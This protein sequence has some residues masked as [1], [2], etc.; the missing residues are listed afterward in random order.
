MVST[1]ASFLVLQMAVPSL[2]P[3]MIF[4]LCVS[5]SLFFF[6]RTPVI[7]DYGF[8]GGCSPK[9]G[10][11]GQVESWVAAQPSSVP[12]AAVLGSRSWKGPGGCCSPNPPTHTEG[13]PRAGEGKAAIRGPAGCVTDSLRPGPLLWLAQP[14]HLEQRD[15][16]LIQVWALLSPQ[17]F[18][19][20][21]LTAAES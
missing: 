14:R 10:V 16:F 15:T 13:K 1:E 21:F 9:T 11:Q 12:V 6:I 17:T 7:L 18:T 19:T 8:G 2:C 4:P 20:A 3:H 5:V